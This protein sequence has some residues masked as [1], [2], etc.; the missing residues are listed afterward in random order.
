MLELFLFFVAD[1]KCIN[2]IYLI[3]HAFCV[4]DHRKNENFVF[5]KD[6]DK[7]PV[8]RNWKLISLN[9]IADLLFRLS[10]RHT[11][12][13]IFMANN[14]TA[15]DC[16]VLGC[17]SSGDCNTA[18][19][20]CDCRYGW[21]GEDCSFYFYQFDHGLWAYYIF[22]LIFFCLCFVAVMIWAIIL[23]VKLV[24]IYTYKISYFK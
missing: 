17:A 18:T 15:Y 7:F 16:T 3:E 21:I 4:F 13:Y 23:I 5:F 10:R 2:I 1:R 24:C 6:S 11:G 14:N 8:P 22:H 20:N 12:A 9:F 19:F